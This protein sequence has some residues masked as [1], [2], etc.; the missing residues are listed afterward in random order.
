MSPRNSNPNDASAGRSLIERLRADPAQ[1][2]RLARDLLPGSHV[3]GG[4]LHSGAVGGGRGR[5]LNVELQGDRAGL[6]NDKATGDGGDLIGLACQTW[7]I[8]TDRIAAELER[9]GYLQRS[10]RS[11]QR[12]R[13][14][15]TDSLPPADAPPPSLR[16]RDR[17]GG[18]L[19]DASAAWLYE[20]GDGRPAFW[21]LRFD[22]PGGGKEIRPARW[23]GKRG[24]WVAGAF[25]APRPIYRLP[26]LLAASAGVMLVVEGEKTA[27][28]A[29]ALFDGCAVTTSSGGSSSA[30]KSDWSALAGRDVLLLPDADSAGERYAAEVAR[31]ARAAGASSVRLLPAAEVARL[32][33]V[34]GDL[35]DGWD[36][37]DVG[38][39]AGPIA[40][41]ALAA[42]AV[43][44]VAAPAPAA[45]TGAAALLNGDGS[46]L[47]A[48][49]AM[50][51]AARLL[52]ALGERVLLARN[53]NGNPSAVYISDD[54]GVW[55]H[56][57]DD[58][59]AAHSTAARD[60]ALSVARRAF[61]GK[62]KGQDAAA[63]LSWALK[64]QSPKGLTD[65]LH[66]CGAAYLQLRRDDPSA[67]SS[68]RSVEESELDD[69]TRY[70]GAPNGVVDLHTGLLLT[71]SEARGKLVTRSLPDAFDAA[72]THPLIDRLFE[73]QDP[74]ESAWLLTGL[75]LALR[76]ELGTYALVIW[77]ETG[78]GKSTLLS[79][80]AA[81]LGGYAVSLNAGTF[82]D[83]TRG[84]AGAPSPDLELLRGRRIA[85]ASE[86][87]ALGADPEWLKRLT[88]GEQLSSRRM[89]QDHEQSFINR[90]LLVLTGND[91]PR[92]GAHDRAILRRL[93]VAHWAA[94]PEAAQLRSM[95]DDVKRDAG[96][97]QAMAALL[98]K[99]SVG[100]DVDGWLAEQPAS[101]AAA[102]AEA[103]AV[104]TPGALAWARDAIVKGDDGDVLGT[105]DL[106]RAA[107]E[108]VGDGDGV[109]GYRS[110]NGFT[111]AVRAYL[112]LPPPTPKR[113][114]GGKLVR[115]WRGYRLRSA[116]DAPP[117]DVQAS[118]DSDLATC[119][120]CG[121]RVPAAD[122]LFGRS[123]CTRCGGDA[124]GGA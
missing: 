35:P 19:L 73:H 30:A 16:I 75:G 102:I 47:D 42:V 34:A 28:R 23:D 68:V 54:A 1:L 100:W 83:P 49:S 92:V 114:V 27:D 61:E 118:L 93:I 119:D 107:R 55:L 31:L 88:G 18:G 20:L 58:L 66:S 99:A 13:S 79:A 6:W 57:R 89:R 110:Q 81:A 22:L 43:D 111:K 24:R 101:I 117:D 78:G 65:A 120:N 60:F 123:G 71:G 10:A 9:L 29:A 77:G 108:E 25:P 36:V 98:V 45:G 17:D 85:Y 82:N 64:S 21:V 15:D 112:A 91:L 2:E 41:D 122:L 94:I 3:E 46:L 62:G 33:G 90:A 50:G 32:L 86:A 37:G 14:A 4:R 80:V 109:E 96:A 84:R 52:D 67:L 26:A 51:D 11:H 105:G 39:D 56:N 121:A 74:N 113:G 8:P 76:G 53:D 124:S 97:R 95:L 5:S 59:G 12:S 7:R 63:A 103:E 87:A 48:R 40:L 104:D 72:A 69:D 106:W 115:G 116:G 70:L 44:A 38:D